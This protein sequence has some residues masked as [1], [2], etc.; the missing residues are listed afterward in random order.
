MAVDHRETEIRQPTLVATACGVANDNGKRI[1]A[2]VIVVGT[3][4]G[5]A[6]KE[7]SVAATDIEH[8]QC[9]AAEDCA[10]V[11][12]T[13]FRQSLECRLRPLLRFENL[14]GNR[15]AELALD[16]ATLF[17]GHE[18]YLIDGQIVSRT[19][20]LFRRGR[21]VGVRMVTRSLRSRARG[22]T[23][24]PAPVAGCEPLFARSQGRCR[25][26]SFAIRPGRPAAIRDRLAE[27]GGDPCARAAS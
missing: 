9:L 13:V 27:S 11:E 2:Q 4:D 19:K 16:M 25:A 12:R 17:F 24:A 7:T 15:H 23:P 22:L 21:G 3:P 6:N 1:D 20:P 10:P 5:A 18:R 26:T 8:T 14:A